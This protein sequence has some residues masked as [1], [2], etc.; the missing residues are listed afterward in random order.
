LTDRQRQHL[1]KIAFKEQWPARAVVYR[2]GTIAT[3]LYICESG[4]AKCYRDLP[5]GT[6]SIAAFVFRHDMFGLAENGSYLNTV[7]TITPFAAYRFPIDV[8]ADLMR[9]DP[10]L[11]IR[12]LCKVAHELR[13]AQRRSI[14]L[15]RNDA[16]GRVVMFFHLLTGV[17]PIQHNHRIELPMSRS[18][19][20]DYL[21]LSGESVS[22]ATT[23]LIRRG[24]IAF[25]G[26]R[27]VRV[28]DK[29]QFE[30]IAT[31]P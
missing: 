13:I 29:A 9:R 22:R 23:K 12:V 31:T 17:K 30:K 28:L 2:E 8:M 1:A 14:M 4:V 3:D 11:E 25:E 18:D 16:V 7:Q 10:E 15:G 24:I 27:A 6:R 5:S 19:I 20:A 26:R 21:A